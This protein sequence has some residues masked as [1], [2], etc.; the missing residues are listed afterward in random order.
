M[1][2][3]NLAKEDT[4]QYRAQ[5]HGL[6]ALSDSELISLMIP[7]KKAGESIQIARQLMQEHNND[8]HTLAKASTE[9]I[10]Y[11]KG[12]GN[13]S[14]LIIAA[15]MEIGRRRWTREPLKRPDIRSS[16]HCY[17]LL[18]PLLIDKAQEEFWVIYLNQANYVLDYKQASTGGLSHVPV[19]MK[20]IFKKAL[21][22]GATQLV[23]AHNHPSGRTVASQSDI[24][25]TERM[26]NA[27]KLMDIRV[28]DH[29]IIGESGYFSFADDNMI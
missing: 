24:A 17:D 28:V 15:A 9:K 16:R 29:I 6:S 3:F 2:Q 20:V 18:M 27:A 10:K 13:T 8:L 26:V 1:T 23:L 19:D 21:E 22:V 14:A 25:L 11:V 12:I 4:P 7:M 5:A